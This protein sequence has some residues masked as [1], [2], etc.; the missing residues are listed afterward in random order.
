MIVG[1]MRALLFGRLARA[2]VRRG[3]A[4]AVHPL[5][6]F[7]AVTASSRAACR[8]FVAAAD[9]PAPNPARRPPTNFDKHL[10]PLVRAFHQREGHG[11]VPD[12]YTATAADVAA[13]GLEPCWVGFRL[14][15]SLS[16]IWTRGAFVTPDKRVTEEMAAYRI[17]ALAALGFDFSGDFI[18]KAPYMAS[19]STRP[20][21]PPRPIK[22]KKAKKSAAEKKMKKGYKRP[23]GSY[24]FFVIENRDE[25][26]SN[27]PGATVGEI[28][29][30]LGADWREVTADDKQ[31]YEALATEDKIRAEM[32]KVAWEQTDDFQIYLRQK[33]EEQ[34][35]KEQA[36][37]L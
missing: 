26:A 27:N 9:E 22:D 2:R 15:N 4:D 20:P 7:P 35:Q 3:V 6:R 23:I 25:V 13:A 1:K 14:G 8:G 21:P 11:D 24:M 16:N 34:R 18:W 31:R 30:L 36:K 17:D 10:L 32:D 12:E 29:K 28:A 19:P 33:E 37:D 5:Y